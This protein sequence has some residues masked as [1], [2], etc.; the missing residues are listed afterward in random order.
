MCSESITAPSR[1]ASSWFSRLRIREAEALVGYCCC[2][3]NGL[4]LFF[5]LA[6]ALLLLLLRQPNVPSF[7][8]LKALLAT[9]T[10]AILEL[11]TPLAPLYSTLP[12]LYID[13]FDLNICHIRPL[14]NNNNMDV[15][16]C[17]GCCSIC[18]PT[19]T[20]RES[21]HHIT[22]SSISPPLH[23]WS[24]AQPNT[25]REKKKNEKSIGMETSAGP[26]PF[27]AANSALV[28]II[29][30]ALKTKQ[31]KTKQKAMRPAREG[32]H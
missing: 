15:C 4:C 25:E 2:C 24:D 1:C 3:Y 26:S 20:L 23:H 11:Y 9:T 22:A 32:E 13:C 10:T 12:I 31:N 19:H 7:G 6:S 5:I 17:A 29:S 27:M 18:P 16:L 8:S 21:K 14:N 28:I 30:L